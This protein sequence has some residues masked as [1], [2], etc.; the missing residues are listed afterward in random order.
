MV[1]NIFL[2][3][4][5]IALLIVGGN[6]FVDSAINFGKK[7]KIPSIIVGATIV[8]IATTLPELLVSTISAAKGSFG[9]S[10][11]NATG[12]VICNTALIAGL[13]MAVMPT[14]LKEKDNPIKYLILIFS[15]VLLLI[16]SISFSGDFRISWMESCVLLV[17]FVLFMTI[18]IVEAKN[19]T[20]QLKLD[21]LKNKTPAAAED[22]SKIKWWKIIVFFILGAGG[23]AGGAILTVN[24][25]EALAKALGI[26]DTFIG[27]TIA[28][29]GTSLPELVS[30]IISIKKKNSDIGYG[31]VIGA[32]ILNITLVTGLSGVI[33]GGAGLPV[34][35]LTFAVS[36]PFVI[37]VSLIFLVPIMAKQKTYRWQGVSLLSLYGAY[38]I[39]LIVATLN[40]IAV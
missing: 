22:L 35:T 26:S 29:I 13:S 32:N 38:M 15:T 12:S 24:N 17:M 14:K 39:Y 1:L 4:L 31:N 33:S 28:A 19:T 23:V 20:K 40:G 11:G 25:A 3:I 34:S 5:G 27:L 6:W 9:L 36:M 10:I 16:F 2:L 21:A 37:L 30:T 18:N 7:T 8:S